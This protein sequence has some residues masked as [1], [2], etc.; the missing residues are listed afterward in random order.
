MSKDNDK[1]ENIP[2][3]ISKVYVSE[4]KTGVRFSEDEKVDSVVYMQITVNEQNQAEVSLIFS[5]FVIEEDREI[6]MQSWNRPPIFSSPTNDLKKVVRRI[7]RW[8]KKQEEK[9]AE[10]YQGI[11]TERF[12]KEAFLTLE[13]ADLNAYQDS[14]K[15]KKQSPDRLE[16]EED[17]F[18]LGLTKTF[19][20]LAATKDKKTGLYSL[21][22]WQRQKDAPNKLAAFFNLYKETGVLRGNPIEDGLSLEE[23]KLRIRNYNQ[24]LK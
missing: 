17:F 9:G 8:E 20:Y 18:E 19:T 21:T 5:A 12:L 10:L 1:Y 2:S 7:S 11:E 24:G 23:V 16:S 13:Q 15:A 22:S 6:R 3:L 4:N 14:L